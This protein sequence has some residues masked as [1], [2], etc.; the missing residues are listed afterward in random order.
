MDEPRSARPPIAPNSGEPRPRRKAWSNSGYDQ[1]QVHRDRRAAL[2]R[3]ATMAFRN[4]NYHEITMDQIAED[5]G[6]SKP[7]LY[8]YVKGKQEILYEGHKL[9]MDF[10]D[11]AV[12]DAE[13]ADGDAAA[14]LGVFC[15][16]YT[17]WT[18]LSASRRSR[19]WPGC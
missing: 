3:R 12:A 6:V 15:R 14:R 11:Q 2:L 17:A 8:N 10:A 4:W 19:V 16:T 1:E 13:A 7:T 18:R 5:L 9:S